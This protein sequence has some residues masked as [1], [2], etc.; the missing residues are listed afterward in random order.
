TGRQD[1]SGAEGSCDYL[2]SSLSK[3]K[4]PLRW[5]FFYVRQIRRTKKNRSTSGSLMGFRLTT[6]LPALAM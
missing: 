1:V 2:V 5:P 6:Y 3:W 4:R